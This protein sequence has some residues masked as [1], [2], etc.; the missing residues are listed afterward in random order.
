MGRCEQMMTDAGQSNLS[1]QGVF[2]RPMR[3][4]DA[5][6]VAQLHIDQIGNGFLASFP[7]KVLAAIYRTVTEA[8]TAFG[9]VADV[10]GQC[11]GFIACAT[12]LRKLYRRVLWRRGP[13]MAMRL[14]PMLAYPRFVRRVLETFWYPSKVRH[15]HLPPAEVLSMATSPAYRKQGVGCSLMHAALAEFR[16][17]NCPSVKVLVGSQLVAAQKF[18]VRIGF[19]LFGKLEHHGA[20]ENIY[21]MDLARE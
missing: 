16:Q 11:E 8:P 21:V 2:V 6:A 13:W 3:S 10:A 1:A 19:H 20:S 15:L 14:M 9:F 18:Y 4:D 5:L 17:R 12:D 7:P